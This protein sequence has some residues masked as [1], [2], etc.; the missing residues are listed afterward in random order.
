MENWGNE[1]N[2]KK[3]RKKRKKSFKWVPPYGSFFRKVRRNRAGIEARKNQILSTRE[4]KKRKKKKKKKER[5]RKNEKIKKRI[6]KWASF[7]TMHLS[8]TS[9][10]TASISRPK[11]FKSGVNFGQV[12][13]SSFC[14]CTRSLGLLQAGPLS[15]QYL[16]GCRE[17]WHDGSQG[18]LE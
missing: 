16:F 11:I 15:I 4:K 8:S 12:C 6:E 9:L 13:K 17:L 18:F 10:S 1:K 5:K 2:M 7:M 14:S 3:K